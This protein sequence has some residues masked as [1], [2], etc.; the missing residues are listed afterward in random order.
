MILSHPVQE[1]VKEAILQTNSTNRY[2]LC[3]EIA[4]ILESRYCGG[5]LEYQSK[6]MYLGTTKQI[7]E[8]IDSFFF[9]YLKLPITNIDEF[10]SF[11]SDDDL[12]CLDES[13]FFDDLEF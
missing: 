2:E 5:K 11:E 1:I 12:D 7:L 3:L 13:D 8:V 4:N 9:R 10:D 6:R